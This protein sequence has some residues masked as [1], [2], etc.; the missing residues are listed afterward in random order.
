MPNQSPAFSSGQENITKA[1][2]Q[3]IA[4]SFQET[5]SRA[6]KTLDNS[7]KLANKRGE[8]LIIRRFLSEL[9]RE[10]DNVAPG[11]DYNYDPVDDITNSMASMTL[12][13]ATINAIKS[14]VRSAVKK[15]T[16]CGRFGHTS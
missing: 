2:L 5:M 14:A 15:C 8:N 3:V 1:D 6:T 9:L 11:D 16:K 13:S 12:N 7:K 4:N 10:K